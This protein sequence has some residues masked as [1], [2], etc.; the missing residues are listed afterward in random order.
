MPVHHVQMEQLDAGFFHR[1][2]F[3]FQSREVTRQQAGGD[4]HR[5]VAAGTISGN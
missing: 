3:A 2:H 4:R 1:A 5:R